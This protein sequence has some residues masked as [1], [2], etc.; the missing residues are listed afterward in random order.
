[1]VKHNLYVWI[2]TF[3]YKSEITVVLGLFTDRSM[4]LSLL[5]SV[6]M[7]GAGLTL[8]RH[9]R[10]NTSWWQRDGSTFFHTKYKPTFCPT[11]LFIEQ[12]YNICGGNMFRLHR[13]YKFVQ[14]IV[15]LDGNL[16]Y[17]FIQYYYTQRDGKHQSTF[18]IGHPISVSFISCHIWCG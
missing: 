17:T 12:I 11:Q 3:Y 16:V 13:C 2:W 4:L 18:F 1:V 6:H 7:F 14:L 5:E 10:C 9:W 8:S 15:E